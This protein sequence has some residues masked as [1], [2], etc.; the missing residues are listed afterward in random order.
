[1][2]LERYLTHLFRRGEADRPQAYMR[3]CLL[4]KRYY[5]NK[6]FI[7]T[8]VSAQGPIIF[9]LFKRENRRSQKK[10]T[11]REGTGVRGTRRDTWPVCPLTRHLLA[12]MV[13]SCIMLSLPY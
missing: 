10:S 4:T 3:Q 7:S 2:F 8:P 11:W 1:M 13:H 5:Q 9:T 12:I 6:K